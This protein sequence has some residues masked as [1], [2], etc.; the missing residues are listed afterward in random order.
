MTEHLNKVG[1]ITHFF[2]KVSAAVVKFE[3][4]LKIGAQV[5][6][7]GERGEAHTSVEFVQAVE[8]LQKDRVPVTEAKKGDEL[9][10]K[11]DKEVQAGD[12]V[13]VVE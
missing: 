13:F 3:Q 10:M 11:V 12:I 5:K 7:T 4:P 9:G 1:V 2:P 8:S 6:I